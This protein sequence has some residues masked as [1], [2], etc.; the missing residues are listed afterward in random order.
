M[1]FFS[2]Q[3]AEGELE[4]L[5]ETGFRDLEGDVQ[6][7]SCPGNMADLSLLFGFQHTLV[8]T[9]PIA[10]PPALGHHMELVYVDIIC[11]QHLQRS[12]EIFPELLRCLSLGLGRDIDLIPH[13]GKSLAELLLAVCIGSC[14]VEIAHAALIGAAKDLYSIRHG[15][16]LDR[17]RAEGVLRDGD[18]GASKRDFS[19]SNTSC[20]VPGRSM[21]DLVRS[22]E[23]SYRLI[24][25]A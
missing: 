15:D 23:D 1:F 25:Y 5:I 14:G 13:T 16:P 2:G 17:K 3:I 6:L 4:R 7:M 22:F 20:N 24:L 18:T 11:A 8:H 10:G 12:V 19:H 21:Y 9:G